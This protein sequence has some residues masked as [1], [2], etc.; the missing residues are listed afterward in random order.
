MNKLTQSFATK[1]IVTICTGCYYN[2]RENL[3]DKEDY[4]VW[5]L[6]EILLKALPA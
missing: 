6:P 3:K 5:M 2:L 4:R 1:D